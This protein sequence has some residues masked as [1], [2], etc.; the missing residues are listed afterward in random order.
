MQP[1]ELQP[2]CLKA[3]Q[4]GATH[5]KPIPSAS[6]VTAPWVRM[7]CQFG[8]ANHGKS[9]SCPPNTPTPEETGKL[10]S[11]YRRAILFHLEVAA[12]PQRREKTNR[13]FETVVET[14]RELFLE[15]YYSA[16]ALL[17][18][19]CNL[20]KECS[21]MKNAP[22]VFPDKARPSMEACGIDVFQ[23]A[24]NNGFS[25]QTLRTR[26]QTRDLFSIVLVD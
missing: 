6:V 13:F 21:I 3:T 19:P 1:E 8:C 11:P 9:Y 20:C 15:G 17:A 26:D 7:K 10:I 18:G 23:T 12:G 22:C 24:R 5:A 2:Y 16:F 25:I 14:E 4:I